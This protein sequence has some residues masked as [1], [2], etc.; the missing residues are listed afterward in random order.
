MGI[1]GNHHSHTDYLQQCFPSPYAN[2]PMCAKEREDSGPQK[3][4]LPAACATLVA[5]LLTQ[6]VPAR[7]G[8]EIGSRLT[9]CL[10]LMCGN[11]EWMR[12]RAWGGESEVVAPGGRCYKRC[13]E[14][15]PH[16]HL[17]VPR[18]TSEPRRR[19]RST[20]RRN[21]TDADPIPGRGD[22]GRQ[23]LHRRARKPRRLRSSRPPS[24]L[25]M[26]FVL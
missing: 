24:E 17:C 8:R 2:T 20:R 7:G 22:G 23:L 19:R 21:C 9:A 16:L 26:P 4:R 12:V 6:L 15:R 18:S 13:R 5:H 11:G 10:S 25:H 14:G 3:G 1:Y